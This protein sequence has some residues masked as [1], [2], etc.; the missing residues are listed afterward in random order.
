MSILQIA[1]WLLFGLSGA[2][3][4]VLWVV[5]VIYATLGNEPSIQDDWP[6]LLTSTAI[7]TA[8]AAVAGAAVWG[9]QKRAAWRWWTELGLALSLGAV[10]LLMQS[11]R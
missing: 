1:N 10:A 8:V 3:A 9:M 2:T 6:A 11:L 7:F 4:L 5:V